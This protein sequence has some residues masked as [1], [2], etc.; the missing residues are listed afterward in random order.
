MAFGVQGVALLA[1]LT[2][3]FAPSGTVKHFQATFDTEFQS[4]VVFPIAHISVVGEGHAQHMGATTAVTTNQTLNFLTGQGLA[5]YELTAANG[6][7]VVVDLDAAT[8]ILPNGVTFAGSYVVTGGTGRFDGAGGTGAILGSATF[9][10]PNNGIGTFALD[11]T[12][13]LPGH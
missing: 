13:T 3:G 5:T 2:L 7:T 12:L 8:V 9:T 4:V 10:G 6:D 1:A 11:G